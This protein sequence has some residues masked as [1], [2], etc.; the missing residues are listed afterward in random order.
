MATE[1]ERHEALKEAVRELLEL[2][3]DCDS[4]V[5]IDSIAQ[6]DR[7]AVNALRGRLARLSQWTGR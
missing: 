3:D 7:D 1:K 4:T 5:R 2:C 6:K